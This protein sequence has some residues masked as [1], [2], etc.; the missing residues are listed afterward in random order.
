MPRMPRTSLSLERMLHFV[1]VEWRVAADAGAACAMAIVVPPGRDHGRDARATSATRGASLA[2]RRAA[3]SQMPQG[4]YL[5]QPRTAQV[6]HFRVA[7]HSD[8]NIKGGVTSH[9]YGLPAIHPSGVGDRI[10]LA[11]P[12]CRPVKC[13]FGKFMR[14]R[15]S[16]KRGSERRLSNAGSAFTLSKIHSCCS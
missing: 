6:D 15:R 1:E 12:P 9:I 10:A 13:Y 11:I 7:R 2:S 14:R 4:A 5:R 3:R 16:W 8:T